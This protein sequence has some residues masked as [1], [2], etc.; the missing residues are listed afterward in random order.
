MDAKDGDE[1]L[2][3]IYDQLKVMAR[4]YRGPRDS[5]MPTELVHEAYLRLSDDGPWQ[6]PTHFRATAAVAMRRLLI[7]RARRRDADKRGGGWDR[8]TLSGLGAAPDIDVIALDESLS[9]L[10]RMDHRKAQIVQLRFFGGLTMPEIA[11]HLSVSLRTVEKD[12]RRARA[13]LSMQLN[14]G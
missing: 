13:W 4:R 3:Q 11:A 14:T 10:E 2:P 5:L 6:S 7:D 8:I 12:W 9:T 1:L